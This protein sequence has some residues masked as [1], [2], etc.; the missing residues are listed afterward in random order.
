M[1]VPSV[2]EP[3]NEQFKIVKSVKN[4]NE[5]E[6]FI[7]WLKDKSDSQLAKRK[8]S[9]EVCAPDKHGA[10]RKQAFI[11]EVCGEFLRRWVY[12]INED[13]LFLL[14]TSVPQYDGQEGV[15][16]ESAQRANNFKRLL[17]DFF[18]T[19]HS[20]VFEKTLIQAHLSA[21]QCAALIKSLKQEH[22]ITSALMSQLKIDEQKLWE[23]NIERWRTGGSARALMLKKNNN[24][25]SMNNPNG[26]E[27]LLQY[28]C[29]QLGPIVKAELIGKF[30]I[31]V[32]SGHALSDLV[33]REHSE[34]TPA[35]V[36]LQKVYDSFNSSMSNIEPA[37]LRDVLDAR[38]K[39]L[40]LP[41]K[42]NVGKNN[43]LSAIKSDEFRLKRQSDSVSS[44]KVAAGSGELDGFCISEDKKSVCILMATSNE[45]LEMQEYWVRHFQGAKNALEDLKKDGV[46]SSDAQLNILVTV[47]S[48][49]AEKAQKGAGAGEKVLEYFKNSLHSHV[50]E[51]VNVLP[52]ISNILDID[53]DVDKSNLWQH[54]NFAPVGGSGEIWNNQMKDVLLAKEEQKGALLISLLQRRTADA[55][56]LFEEYE[57][58][59][60][61]GSI[62]VS[63]TA[64]QMT[65]MH[66]IIA[67]MLKN[68]DVLSNIT[69]FDS[70]E[71]KAQRW[72]L[73]SIR[74]LQSS[75]SELQKKLTTF[76]QGYLDKDSYQYKIAIKNSKALFEQSKKL[77]K[78]EDKLLGTKLKEDS[79]INE[80]ANKDGGKKVKI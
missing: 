29:D 45:F 9:Y 1:S 78:F 56:G 37:E 3:I 24:Q 30:E 63:K 36:A 61:G 6:G 33:T 42:L 20:D 79:R 22:D 7:K 71:M 41:M 48:L 27:P 58:N 15:V 74:V 8:H 40:F 72:N 25:I 26:F 67:L 68:A 59:T 4:V 39:E 44:I 10:E 2:F 31:Y 13:C 23:E 76:A 38:F 16:E 69:K 21:Q 11:S 77:K 34:S 55:L 52:L 35:L 46:C 5:F 66:K 50:Q 57:F 47:P 32:K 17:E 28:I 73:E 19:V 64:T 54:V 70:K 49:V 65:K 62:N 60:T 53:P 14:Q 51:A 75:T 80:G 12:T 18:V 43:G